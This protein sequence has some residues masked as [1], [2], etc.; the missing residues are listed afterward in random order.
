MG[1]RERERWVRERERLTLSVV[2]GVIH[3]EARP[4]DGLVRLEL[5]LH[6]V[7]GGDHGV[8]IDVPT[9]YPHQTGAV[10]S[11]IHLV[12]Y[13]AQSL[14]HFLFLKYPCKRL[15]KFFSESTCIP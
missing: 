10:L 13:I 11:V 15:N 5:E 2:D 7:G 3:G 8:G 9:V 12:L 6:F 4:C 14:F 1:E